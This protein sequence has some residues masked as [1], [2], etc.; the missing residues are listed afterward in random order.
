MKVVSVAHMRRIEEQADASG[1]SYDTMMDYAGR[2]AAVSA[3]RMLNGLNRNDDT[4]WVTLLIGKGNNGGDGLVCA[5][6]LS[7]IHPTAQIRLYM[8][9]RRDDDDPLMT[10]LIEAGL[11]IAYAED[12]HDNRVLRN[13]VNTADLL[14][15]ALFGIGVRLPIQGDAAT[16]L[17]QTNRV[18]NERRTQ[19]PEQYLDMLANPQ[20][21][22]QVAPMHILAIDC[23]SGLNCDTGELDANT[24]HA[25]QTITFIAGKTGLVTYP[26]AEAVGQLQVAHIG[27]PTDLAALDEWTPQLISKQR[28]RER[29]PKRTSNSHK[30]THGKALVIAGSTNYIGAAG[31]AATAAYRAG[32]GLVAV[33]TPGPVASMLASTHTEPTW[34]MLGHDQGVIAEKAASQLTDNLDGY[35]TVLI[36]PG[37][38]QEATTGTF[39]TQILNIASTAPAKARKRAIGFA[40]DNT[41]T[42]QSDTQELTLP[43]LVIDAD[44]LNLLAKI[45]DWPNL[46]PAETIITPHPG[47]M[48]RLT[49]LSN[50]EIQADRINIAKAKAAEW[51]IIVVLKGAHTVIATPDGDV[52]ILPFKNDGLATA[53]TGDVLAGL[54]TGLRAQGLPAYDAAVIGGY[55]HGLAGELYN[56]SQH[57]RSL[58]ASDLLSMIGQAWQVIEG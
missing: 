26:G 12:D 56:E 9:N 1:F 20:H 16:I 54:I 5:R 53:G 17:R 33:A 48:A 45:A 29:L 14:I 28:V 25:D 52:S 37:I 40:T 8:L 23:P 22:N 21:N 30:G 18:I 6:Y 47:E 43:P 39:L 27:T 3:S 41:E 4:Q 34:M 38:G 13:M 46:L 19:P 51:N 24:I 49:N 58:I 35:A 15:D 31:L 10:P 55:V 42:S 36:G 57:P 32:A 50:A 11:F 7:E 2:A 44:G